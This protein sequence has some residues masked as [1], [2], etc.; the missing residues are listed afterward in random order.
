MQAQERANADIET[1]RGK[2]ASARAGH[3]DMADVQE[4]LKL[5]RT[6]AEAHEAELRQLQARLRERDAD[7]V[8][9]YGPVQLL[10]EVW[11]GLQ[12]CL[13]PRW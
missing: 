10:H 4:S 8:D 9:R 5:A 13:R 12:V 7:D 11:Q 6:A 3:K 2:L 1:L